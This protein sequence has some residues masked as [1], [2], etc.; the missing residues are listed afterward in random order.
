MLVVLGFALLPG[1]LYPITW[2][3]LV[4]RQQAQ[5]ASWRFGPFHIQPSL[6]IRN[7]GYDSNVYY[8]PDA[9][10]DY[11]LTAG[12][13]FDIFLPVKKK[14]LF[15]VYA[16]PQYVYFKE[17][18][19]ERTWN[20]YTNGWVHLLLNKFLVSAGAG[21]SDARERFSTEIDIRPRR[22]VEDFQ[23][24]ILWQKSRK[25]SFALAGRSST[26]RYESVEYS[27]FNIS[28]RLDRTE[29]TASAFIY[30]QATS[31]IRAFAEGE[32]GTYDFRDPA[33]GRDSESRA[34][35]GGFE[36]S[37]WSRLR[38][39][40][41]FGYKK[42]RTRDAGLPDFEGFVGE[43]SLTLRVL[44]VLNVRCSY[45]RDVSFSIWFEN[46]FYIEKSA[47]GGASFYIMKR[48]VRLDYDYS[49]GHNS[50]PLPEGMTAPGA[51]VSKRLD[52]MTVHSVGLYIR[53][54]EGVGLGVTAGR[55]KRSINVLG[56][57]ADRDFV[58]LN[59]TYD[60]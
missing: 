1:R 9:V 24:S 46:P 29:Q 2:K 11:W 8:R 15:Q 20:Y 57:T 59:L 41:R 58:G 32:Y 27:G 13:A 16:S 54:Q 5:A 52:D 40:V 21:W 47:G 3:G 19:R 18:V 25:F 12:P 23:A 14:I 22:R 49:K 51:G 35:Y 36:L 34:V 10:A 56:W 28:Q 17:T 60:F 31:K 39:T 44:R 55:L 33:S 37:S 42:F 53:V 43:A 45:R 6:V 4:L 30:Y 38:G 7:A 26:H 48:K 50:Y